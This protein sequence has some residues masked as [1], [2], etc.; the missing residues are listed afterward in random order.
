MRVTFFGKGGSGKT[1]LASAFIKFLENKN[2]EVLAVDADINVN[3]AT[4]L[5]MPK[6]Y[7]GDIF[8]SICE[9]LETNLDKPRIGSSP[10]TKDS[11]FIKALFRIT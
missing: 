6:K 10:V 7:L 2:K 9:S 8:D 1:T 4:A 5:N 11:V 3:L